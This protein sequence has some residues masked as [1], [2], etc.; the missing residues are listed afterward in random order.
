MI[1]AL[2][3]LAVFVT[4]VPLSV[5]AAD[6]EKESVYE[7]VIRTGTL[8]CGYGTSTM[9][10]KNLETGAMEGIFVDMIEEMAR[11]SKIKIEWT[12]E[13]DW[14]QIN[15]ALQSGKVDAFCSGMANDAMR[16]KYL[17][18]S[19]PMFHMPF[20]VFVRADDTRFPQGDNLPL[21]ILNNSEFAVAY[22]EGDV[23]E[24][25]A[26]TEMPDVRG[27]PLPPLGTPADNLMNLL[28][29]KTD[30]VIQPLFTIQEYEKANG[31][32]AVRR[33]DLATPLRVYGNV[34]A[35]DIREQPLIN[36]LNS[37]VFELVHSGAYDRIMATY[38]AEY[39]GAYLPVAKSYEMSK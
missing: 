27:V 21:S 22:T 18:Y 34:I 13:V 3:L 32:G 24:T 17:G 25:I 36:F 8:R 37:G 12:S 15:A 19:D 31:A 29:K 7:R 2:T 35:V 11:L 23:I 39:P 14:G 33:L 30:I 5:Q 1:R 26:Q 6:K 10:H 38:D 28:A 16:G 20:D 9:V 4:L